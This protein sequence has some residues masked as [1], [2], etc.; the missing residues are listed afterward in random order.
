VSETVG[1]VAPCGF[2]LAP[3]QDLESI[4]IGCL[5]HMAAF[6]AIY[7]APDITGF[8]PKFT[9][10]TSLLILFGVTR[11]G[12]TL[13][14]THGLPKLVSLAWGLGVL[15]LF[16]QVS[17]ACVRE[18]LAGGAPPCLRMFAVRACWEAAW[19]PVASLGDRAR[20]FAA[21][22]LVRPFASPPP[23]PS[24]P[25]STLRHPLASSA[26]WPVRPRLCPST[27]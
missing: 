14:Y 27:A 13:A 25:A 26:S 3:A 6:F 24:R 12:H 8:S 1:V 22:L 19:G 20:F 10:Y 16:G 2:V 15:S 9:A 7:E 18:V 17:V 21:A 5:V 4:P 23:P 11:V